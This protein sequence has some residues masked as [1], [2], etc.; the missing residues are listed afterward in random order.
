MLKGLK[1]TLFIGLDFDYEDDVSQ[2]LEFV[3]PTGKFHMEMSKVYIR[4]HPF[5]LKGGGSQNKKICFAAQQKF[6]F[7]S[8]DIIFFLQKQYF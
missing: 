7:A 4:E 6:V 5:N 1:K 8:R 2:S 3:D